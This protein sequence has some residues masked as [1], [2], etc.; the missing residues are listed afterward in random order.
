MLVHLRA[1]RVSIPAY[2]FFMVFWDHRRVLLRTS[3]LTRT[4]YVFLYRLI[5][6]QVAKPFMFTWDVIAREQQLI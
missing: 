5:G 3:S 1:L 4:G 2:S 6:R